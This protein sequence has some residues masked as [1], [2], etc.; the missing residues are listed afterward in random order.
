MNQSAVPG[1]TA[2]VVD[3]FVMSD[4]KQPGSKMPV[5]IVIGKSFQGK[6]EYLGR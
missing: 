2:E 4:R 6:Q 1:L 5:V 3:R